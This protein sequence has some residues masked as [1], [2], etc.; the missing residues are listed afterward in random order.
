MP[1][2]WKSQIP[3]YRNPESTCFWSHFQSS[4]QEGD[5]G[6]GPDRSKQ[7]ILYHMSQDTPSLVARAGC[8]K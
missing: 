6:Y 7:G 8:V 4:G 1:P 2:E 3:L 5:K